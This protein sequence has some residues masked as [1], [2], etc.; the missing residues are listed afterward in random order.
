M[1]NQVK[2]K[3][4]EVMHWKNLANWQKLLIILVSIICFWMVGLI[5]YRM[6]ELGI[7]WL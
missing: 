4:Y 7:G 3:R 6:V 5:V 2:E 1:E